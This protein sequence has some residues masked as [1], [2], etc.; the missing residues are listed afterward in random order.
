VSDFSQWIDLAS[1][2]VGGGVLAANDEFF[3]PKENLLKAAQPVW[4]ADKY[5]DRGKWMD[6]WETRRRRTPGFDWCIVRLGIPGILRGIVVDTSYFKGNYP[7][8][9]SLEACSL[10]GE[11]SLEEVNSDSV[12]WVEVLSKS[13]LNGDARNSFEVSDS[14][15]YTHLRFSIYPDGGVARLRMHGEALPDWKRVLAEGA[16][17]DLAAIVNGGRVLD[18]SDR[19]FGAPQNLL[20]PCKPANMGDGWETSRRR[21]PGHDWVTIR[22]GMAGVLRQIDVDTSHFKGNYPES[23]SLEVSDGASHPWREALARTPLRANS[24]HR[25]QIAEAVSASA[26]RFNIFPDG[27]VARLRIYGVPTREGRIAEGL[28]WLNAMPD[29][30][31][32]AALLNCCGSSA[33]ARTVADRRPFGDQAALLTAAAE[34]CEKLGED[35]WRE[36]FSH[37][38]K[39]GGRRAA[40]PEQARRWSE[41]EQ[42]TVASSAPRLLEELA[43]ANERYQQ[44]FGYI[45]IVCATGKSTEEMLALLNKRMSNNPE[46]E[47][48]VAAGEQQKITRLR[49]EKLLEL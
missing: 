11:D 48:R 39:I 17:I 22:L 42:R 7:E 18:A 37:H 26:V 16:C 36:A 41:Q 5:T 1:E 21:G 15:R 30:A 19:F 31:A 2:R 43:A 35:D 45:F 6:G 49:L 40:Q 27:G 32:R 20:M 25:L 46:T 28:R 13:A 38:P 14:R 12:R 24:V 33:W 9:C 8:H 44:R 34:V 4:I 47:L 10:E 23:C 3:A 29:D